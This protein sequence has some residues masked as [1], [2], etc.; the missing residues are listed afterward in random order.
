MG[1]IAPAFKTAVWIRALK[2][3]S[4][5]GKSRWNIW[6]L[7]MLRPLSHRGN[8]AAGSWASLSAIWVRWDERLPTDVTASSS[9]SAAG[10]DV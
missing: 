8:T 4:G 9:P 10:H 1:L 3:L 2:T 5:G 7:G 6:L